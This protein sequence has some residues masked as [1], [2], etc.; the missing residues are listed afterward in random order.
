MSKLYSVT[1]T[2]THTHTPLTDSC[3]TLEA[4][5]LLEGHGGRKVKVIDSLASQWD[6]LAKALGFEEEAI[7]R[8][9]NTYLQSHDACR[10]MLHKWL[11]GNEGLISPVVW[12]TLI[13]C[14]INSGLVGIADNLKEVLEYNKTEA[15]TDKLTNDCLNG[16][17]V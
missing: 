5:E 7:Q 12:I 4:L 2:H 10:E 8:I 9:K 11:E 13:Q 6:E 1:H 3:P 15:I 16:N 14:L 17:E